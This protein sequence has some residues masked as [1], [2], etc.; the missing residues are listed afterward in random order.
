M[1]VEEKTED[2]GD[3]SNVCV[4]VCVC[5]VERGNG[6]RWEI[7]QKARQSG[8]FRRGATTGGGGVAGGGGGAMRG[9]G[10]GRTTS[11][12]IRQ[13]IRC[14]AIGCSQFELLASPVAVR[15]SLPDLL[16]TLSLSPSLYLPLFPLF[17]LFFSFPPIS[18][19][20]FPL[21][22]PPLP[23]VPPPPPPPPPSPPSSL[24]LLSRPLR[25]WAPARRAEK[26]S[27]KKSNFV[28]MVT[29]VR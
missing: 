14:T 13:K 22:A 19:T 29:G 3:G 25:E 15:Q 11:T 2:R 20:T 16:D 4:C 6:G 7:L 12:M 27:K 8:P 5:V 18:P 21:P 28:A 1:E 23:P 24:H 9:L 10:R 17:S 26:T